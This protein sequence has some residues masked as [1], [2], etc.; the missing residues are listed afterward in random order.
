M[1]SRLD[2]VLAYAMGIIA[3]TAIIVTTHQ[4]VLALLGIVVI[5]AALFL[6]GYHSS[7]S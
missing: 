7:R 6:Y 1:Q 4:P 3:A 5:T 2:N